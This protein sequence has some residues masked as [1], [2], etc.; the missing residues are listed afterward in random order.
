[1]KKEIS[2]QIP[3]FE[4]SVTGILNLPK[5]ANCVILLAHGAGAG[6]RHPFMEQI[7]ESLADQGLGTLRFN[8][9]YMEK[10]NKAPDR[11]KKA[12][13]AISASLEALKTI[14]QLPIL[15]AGKSFGGRMVSHLAALQALEGV[16]GLVF[17]GFPLHA[18]G[19][20]GIERA[21]HLQ[22]VSLPML[23]LQGTRDTLAQ[24]PMIESV[25]DQLANSELQIIDGA[26]HSFKM[27]KRSGKTQ[28]E[29]IGELSVLVRKFADNLITT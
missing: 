4:M 25:C 6:M 5:T 12:I 21:A 16:V 1:M 24:L 18:S 3:E 2:I 15:L 14:S 28:D 8:F 27:L 23:F 19:K 29:V 10:G 9:I 22:E 20:P 11:P 26:D 17:L 13:A 7:S